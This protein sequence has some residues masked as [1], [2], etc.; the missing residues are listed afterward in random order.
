[1]KILFGSD[2]SFNSFEGSI[3]KEKAYSIM[4]NTAEV[5]KK[6]D[7][8]ILNLEN[9]M[10]DEKDYTPIVKTGPNLISDESYMHFIDALKPTALGL[11][12]NHLYDFGDAAYKNTLRLLTENG[13][14]YAGAGDNI[15]EAYKPVIFDDGDKKVAV[16]C[17]CENEYGIAELN[18]SG[19]AGYQLGR[20]TKAIKSAIKDNMLPIIFFHGGNEYNPY[21][22]PK[23]IE[24]YRHFVD[25]G[26]KAVVAMHTHC[27]QGYE[28]YEGVP[29]I[30]SMGNFYF[31]EDGNLKCWEYGYMTMMNIADEIT[32]EIIPYTF[33]FDNHTLLEGEDK[34]HFMKYIAYISKDYNNEQLMRD[35]FDSWTRISGLFGYINHC[36]FTKDMLDCDQNK[37]R[38]L[39]NLFSCEAH[40]E[41][42]EKST[43]VIYDGRIEE[44]KKYEGKIRKLQNMEIPEE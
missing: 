43:K 33:D 40:N 19:S 24:L 4:K 26:A 28:I 44:V 16:F 15:D 34:E 10:G 27:P 21:P 17:V 39:K 3:T 35:Y 5:F 8:S 32:V 42:I 41:L 25:L 14:L 12:N 31:P 1:M 18:K 6:A 20:V 13:Y 37:I 23:K 9:I 22:S 2:I 38:E 11:A 7:F 36:A 30:Y 29:I